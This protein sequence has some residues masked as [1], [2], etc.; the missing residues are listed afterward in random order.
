MNASRLGIFVGDGGVDQPGLLQLEGEIVLFGAGAA[1][2]LSMFP[3]DRLRLVCGMKPDVEALEAAGFAV[4]VAPP[5]AAALA[6]VILPRAKAQARAVVA[7]ALDLAGVA[8]IDGQKHDGVDSLYREMRGRAEC[9]PAFS[10]AHG[11]AFTA[12]AEKGAFADWARAGERAANRDGFVTQP[13]VFSADAIDPASALLADALPPVL[14]RHVADF[15]AGWGFLAGEILKREGVEVL[16]LVEADH[17]ALDCARANVTDPRAAFH[18]ADA[19]TWRAE[20]PLDAV[21]M[22]PPFHEGRKGVPE[23]G[24]GFIRNAAAGLAPGGRLYL[25]ANR[26]LPYEA[27]LRDSFREV[28][29]LGGD[30]RF[31]LFAAAHPVRAGGRTVTRRRLRSRPVG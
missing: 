31:K 13:G 24:Q 11:K 6:V 16:D 3:K 4:S 7:R 29:E 28:E 26:H 27:A 14:G 22:N 18:W 23:L 17:A 21:V 25:V 20:A 2:D 10:K 15:G 30:T 19:C 8:V 5:E 1:T 9:G 12:R